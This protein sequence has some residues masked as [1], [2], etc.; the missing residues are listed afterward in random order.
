MMLTADAGFTYA[1]AKLSE[2]AEGSMDKRRLH[3]TI[4]LSSMGVTVAS[5]L[6]MKVWNR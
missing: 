4:A 1:G 5:A 6:M 3:R 2:E